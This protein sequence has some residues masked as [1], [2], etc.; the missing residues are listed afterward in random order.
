MLRFVASL[1]KSII[2][3]T[4][5]CAKRLVPSS[6]VSAVLAAVLSACG[7]GASDSTVAAVALPAPVAAASAAATPVVA[8][9]T[10]T[11][12]AAPVTTAP[13]PVSAARIASVSLAQSLLFPSG[14]S[15]LVLVQGKAVLLMVNATTT[16]S[17]Q[18]KPAGTVRV[19]TAAGVLLQSMALMPPTKALAATVPDVP[20]FTTAYSAMVPAS[21]VTPGMQLTISLANGQTA[22]VV[23]PRVGG[24]VAL[25]LMAVPIQMDAA[26]GQPL[27]DASSDLQAVMPLQSV[28]YRK[29]AAYLSPTKL[30]TIETDWP[31]AMTAVLAQ[32]A[33]LYRLEGSPANTNYYGFLPKRT[34]GQVG[35]GYVGGNAAVGFDLPT[36][37]QLVL[38]TLIHELGHNL[39]LQHAPCGGPVNATYPYNGGFLGAPGRYI[40]G[41]N[42]K[43][44]VFTDPRSTTN[45]DIM[46]YC[47]GATFSDY[48]YRLMQTFITPADKFVISGTRAAAS[49]PQQLLL[50]SGQVNAGQA[51]LKPAK[52]MFGEAQ[53]PTGGPYTLRIVGEQGTVDYAFTPMVVD[54]DDNALPFIFSVPHPGVIYNMTLLKGASVLTQRTAPAAAGAS[55]AARTTAASMSSVQV[56]TAEKSGVLTLTWDSTRYP[57]LGVVHVGLQRQ[58]LAQ[59]LVGG[60][61]AVKLH[62]L[63]AGGNYEF[64]LSDGLNT[65]L[66]TV[67][68]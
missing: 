29:H 61:A 26:V 1:K 63:P 12:T 32:V 46:S 19:E 33:E 68:R 20:S 7:G 38:E 54:H 17:A 67:S 62:A 35:I 9:P 36:D 4:T 11:P 59:D 22:T 49:G 55:A 41:Y 34:S 40:W 60:T 51:E 8:T 44:A 52:T 50:V 21:L 3:F 66:L 45:H 23:N 42:V 43:T 58:V 31:A 18:A 64:S 28:T 25:T 30:P 10:P 39:N 24:G 13:V 57:H 48:N 56:L 53:L 5:F 47:S 2:M 6:F 37:P 65:V 14:D 27:A 15:A 16:N